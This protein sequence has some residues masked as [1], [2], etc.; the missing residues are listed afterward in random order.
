MPGYGRVTSE[1]VPV[2]P[3]SYDYR[4]AALDALHFPKLIDRFWQNL[5]RATGYKVQ[6]FAVVEPQRRLAPHLHAAVRGAIPREVIRQVVAATYH[7]VWW[8]PHDLPVY[9]DRDPEWNE[10]IRGYVD[11]AT[12]EPLP[13]WQA[14]LDAIDADPLARPAHVMRLGTQ[15]DAQGLIA[16]DPETDRRIGYLCKYLTKSVART[17]DDPDHTSPARA[18]HLDRLAHEVRWLPCSSRCSNW[19]RYGIQPH[20]A[21]AGLRPGYCPAKAH[22]SEHL[23]LGGRRVLVSRLWTGKTLGRHRADRGAV[24][25]AALEEA[26]IDVDDLDELSPATTDDQGRARYLWL[27]VTSAEI[28]AATYVHVMLAAITQRQRWREQYATAT[29]VRAGPAPPSPV[30]SSS[31][32]RQ[33]GN[34]ATTTEVV[35]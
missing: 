30:A 29:T 14:A 11:P 22:D 3:A 35:R 31:D 18:R 4:R 34:S 8:P 9:V 26:G 27:P 25:R 17:Y 33:F 28:D 6:Y 23:G 10:Q 21:T 16:G 13:I 2:D 1:G 7:Q 15:I 32:V 20:A 24:V 12:R 5:R 19:L